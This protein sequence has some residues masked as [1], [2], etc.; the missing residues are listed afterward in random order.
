MYIIAC[1]AHFCHLPGRGE[2]GHSP[3]GTSGSAWSLDWGPMWFGSQSTCHPNA[4]LTPPTLPTIPWCPY[5][6]YPLLAPWIPTPLPPQVPPTTHYPP[7]SPWHP[8]HPLLTP[9]C[10]Y[11]PWHPLMPL[12][13]CQWECWDPGLSPMW[14]GSQSTSHPQCPDTPL[15]PLHPHW[16]GHRKMINLPGKLLHMKDLLPARVTI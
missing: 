11:T 15:M 3:R 6:P 14:L 16:L 8:L 1:R 10:P 7:A 12:H 4:S 13:P 2:V 5:T 9:W